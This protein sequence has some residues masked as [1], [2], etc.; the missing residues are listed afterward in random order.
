MNDGNILSL[1][2][3]FVITY[4]ALTIQGFTIWQVFLNMIWPR[5]IDHFV[6]FTDQKPW[7]HVFLF[8]KLKMRD[9][10][11]QNGKTIDLEKNG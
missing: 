7:N 10:F 3:I 5:K 4:L 6:Y 11:F 2:K 9:F 1:M 8:E